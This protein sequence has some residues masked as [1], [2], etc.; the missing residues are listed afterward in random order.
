VTDITNQY[1]GKD[2]HYSGHWS[3]IYSHANTA[4]LDFDGKPVTLKGIPVTVMQWL[5]AQRK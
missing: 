5:A 4:T 1:G 2:F 3:W